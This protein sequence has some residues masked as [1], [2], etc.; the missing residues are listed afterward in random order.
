MTETTVAFNVPR[1][2]AYITIQQVVVYATSFVHYVLL[3]RILNLSQ[4]GQISLLGAATGVF[5]TLTQ[6]ALPTAATRFISSDIG[7]GNSAEASAVARRTLGL[8][9]MIATP[10][11]I[12]TLFASPWIA[13]TV[14]KTSDPTILITA[15]ASAFLLDLTTLYGAYFVGVGRY[16]DMAY[17]NI[18]FHPLSRGLGLIL[19]YEGLGVLGI[20]IGWAV[21]A[22]ATL[23]LSLYLWKGKLPPTTVHFPAKPLFAFSLPLFATGLVALVQNW[24]DITLLQGL[25][26]QFSTTGA[27]YIVVSSV[28]FLSI[29]WAPAAAALYPALS[30]THT[31]SG[32]DAVSARLGIATRLVN[33]T[34][35]PTGAALAAI[36][37]T[38]LAAVYGTRLGAQ[39]AVPFAILAVTVIFS[40]QAMLL[41]T[42][43]Q[44][45]NRTKPILA[46]SLAAVTVDLAT[47]AILATSLGTTAAAIG[48]ALLAIA[49]TTLAWWTLRR[50][51]SVPLTHGA[52]KALA[53]TVVTATLLA[54]VDY[55]L[56]TS[57][58]LTPF[59]RLP[60]LAIVFALSFM[61][62]SRE[63]SVFTAA[64]FWL[65]ENA[66]PLAVE[67][68]LTIVERLLVRSKTELGRETT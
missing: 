20:P 36:A 19:A 4:I 31:A 37:P 2:T 25:L 53:V 28:S 33:L 47:V 48:R 42:T 5:S 27:Y 49:T 17:Q 52:S 44:A 35:L 59:Y 24:G 51:L 58:H 41:T 14:F 22:L 3:V 66:L 21:G 54:I 6:L 56:T 63:L 13:T 34:V 64:D 9:L 55:L 10:S 61:I 60:T 8:V 29:L 39:A 68:Y 67:P 62:V 11:L 45:V 23:L 57:L 7:A 32:P 1:G 16:V 26:G 46:I 43:L 38:A 50:V 65:L 40:A 12:V 18:L 15:F 30:S